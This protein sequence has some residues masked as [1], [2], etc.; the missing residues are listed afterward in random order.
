MN[1]S[2]IAYTLL[3]ATLLLGITTG[4]LIWQHGTLVSRSEMLLEERQYFMQA[5]SSTTDQLESERVRASSTITTLSEQVNA[6]ESSLA[7]TQMRLRGEQNRNQDFADQLTD[8]AGTVGVLDKLSKTDRE[9]LQKYSKVYF[10]NENYRPERLT[11]IPTRYVQPGKKDQYFHTAAWPFLR[12]MID[13]AAKAGITLQVVSAFRSFDEQ[14]ELKAQFTQ[15]YG[16]GA[17]A[18][19]AD[20][21]FSEHQLGTAVDLTDPSTGG[22]F[23]S[24]ASTSAYAWLEANA[25]RYGFI[26]SYP[27]NNA[28]YIFEPW[29]WRFVGV[30]LARD[31]RRDNAHFYDWDQR[32]IDEY[33]VKIFD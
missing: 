15:Q 29:H 8:L 26:L 3:G 33:L 24:F 4:Y 17:N 11:Q 12:S 10:L 13:D 28:F 30:A 18:F 27:E 22:T 23:T 6:L 2:L 14:I 19:S 20:Q 16:S 32:K 7:D 5:L 31:L 1:Q 21:G 25:H 9:L